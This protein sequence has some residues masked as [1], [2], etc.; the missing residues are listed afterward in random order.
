MAS[1]SPSLSL[2]PDVKVATQAQSS[3]ASQAASSQRVMLSKSINEF[4]NKNFV[5]LFFTFGALTT[6][7]L[8]PTLC[9]IGA[10]AG[11]IAQHKYGSKMDAIL[12]SGQRNVSLINAALTYVG[13]A[14]SLL[15]Y[16]YPG[17]VQFIPL[18]GGAAIGSTLYSAY[19][20]F[21]PIAA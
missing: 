5:V 11:A 3:T 9:I 1:P 10:A 7:Y 19:R 6:A 13:A 2:T 16:S 20:K 17:L 12:N 18:L 8:A 4:V 14:G 21:Y 15:S